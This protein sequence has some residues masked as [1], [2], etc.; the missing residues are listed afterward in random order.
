MAYAPIRI[1]CTILP[2]DLANSSTG[3]LSSWRGMTWIAILNSSLQV[4]FPA[5]ALYGMAAILLE[6][7]I[8]SMKQ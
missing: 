7:G 5:V 8:V 1:G 2:Q 3:T 4:T 6:Q